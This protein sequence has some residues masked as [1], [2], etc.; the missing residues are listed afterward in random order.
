MKATL[1]Q[2]EWRKGGKHRERGGTRKE[3]KGVG[4]IR[5]PGRETWGT[6][7]GNGGRG[8]RDVTHHHTITWRGGLLRK[9]EEG[10]PSTRGEARTGRESTKRAQPREASS[11]V[12]AWGPLSPEPQLHATM[13]KF[14]Y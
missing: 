9:G 3:R 10:G 5:D 8:S 14:G 6:A 1:G 2:T 13:F 4:W 7:Q 12:E 11:L